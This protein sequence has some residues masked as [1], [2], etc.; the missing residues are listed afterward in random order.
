M[1]FTLNRYAV[2]VYAKID[3]GKNRKKKKARRKEHDNF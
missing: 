1:D 3:I 2:Y